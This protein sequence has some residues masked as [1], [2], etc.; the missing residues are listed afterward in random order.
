[1][2]GLS[3]CLG[4]LCPAGAGIVIGAIFPF[5]LNLYRTSAGRCP[6]EIL[7]RLTAANTL[8]AIAG[9]LAAGFV[10][11]SV[12][13]LWRSIHL[14]AAA[15]GL[16]GAALGIACCGRRLALAVTPLSAGLILFALLPAGA[17]VPV[18]SRDGERILETWESNHGI[19]SVVRQKS[20]LKLRCNYNYTLGSSLGSVESRRQAELPL[21]IHPRP[22]SVLFIGLATGITPGASLSFPVEKVTVCELVPDVVAASRR[23]FGKYTNGLF[24]DSRVH[25]VIEDGRNI[26][27]GER[28]LYDV[29]IGDLFFPWKAGSGSLYTIEHFRSVRGRLAEGGLYYQWLPLYQLSR[30]DFFCIARTML[31]TFPQ[32]TL[33]RGDFYR[34]RPIV[35]LAGH[36]DAS[37]LD[38]GAMARAARRL[39]EDRAQPPDSLADANPFV[40]YA[41]NL[42]ANREL[43]ANAPIN[44]DDRPL[45]EYLAPMTQRDQTVGRASWLTGDELLGLLDELNSL[46]P[47]AEDRMLTQL[48]SRQKQ[49][50]QAGLEAQKANT[51]NQRLESAV[52]KDRV[53]KWRPPALPPAAPSLE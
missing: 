36:T 50:V 39:G 24:N 29:I 53:F 32:V 34:S 23:H 10:M 35:A 6:G 5:I 46:T 19:V 4:S 30:E 49:C 13:G 3:P 22:S 17:R 48:T 51:G 26:L 44:T 43:F 11:T 12:F 38:P 28:E 18:P 15:Y 21:A 33:W 1:M 14:V 16:L 31:E 42:T 8:G 25:I 2:P 7:G 45:I 41:G 27:A 52:V 20:S 9:S 40:Y 47:P 37:P